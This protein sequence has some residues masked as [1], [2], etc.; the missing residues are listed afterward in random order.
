MLQITA[1]ILD[2]FNHK[3]NMEAPAKNQ[4]V[5]TDEFVMHT[6]NNLLASNLPSTDF[7][8]ELL[9][10]IIEYNARL[11]NVVPVKYNRDLGLDWLD[12]THVVVVGDLHGQFKDLLSIILDESIGGKP[13]PRKAYIFNGDLVDRGNMSVE[14][15]LTVFLLQLLYKESVNIIRGNHETSSMNTTY[16][17]EKEVLLKYNKPILE[18]FRKAFR[19]LPFA[20]VVEDVVFVTHGGL[21]PKSH[22]MTVAELNALD[23]VVEPKT[24]SAIWELLWCGT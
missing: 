5:L 3:Y 8:V 24:D 2:N 12:R 19:H 1:D 9:N 13:T 21:G 16:G 6:I 23:R 4:P 7:V 15:L 10:R 18:L 11:P 22:A 14:I 17:F 20:A